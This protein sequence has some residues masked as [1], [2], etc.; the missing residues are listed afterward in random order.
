MLTWKWTKR[1]LGDLK[2]PKKSRR[3]LFWTIWGPKLKSRGAQNRPL[4]RPK[5]AKRLHKG[6]YPERLAASKNRP[7]RDL[8][9]KQVPAASCIALGTKFAPPEG[10]L[11][12]SLSML[13]SMFGP[14]WG[15]Q[16]IQRSSDPKK[17]SSA[18]YLENGYEG[19]RLIKNDLGM[20]IRP[21]PS[22]MRGAIEYIIKN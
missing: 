18:R 16:Q 22:G 3:R 1:A 13:G 2:R 7:G 9:S 20:I 8:C 19:D 5:S 4:E 17:Q 12:P 14:F 11:E 21:W 6:R 10:A 15:N